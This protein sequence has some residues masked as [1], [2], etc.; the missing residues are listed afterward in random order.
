[1][2]KK[3]NSSI[4]EISSY[5]FI[6][7]FLFILVGFSVDLFFFDIKLF[8]ANTSL[9]IG[10]GLLL[11]STFLIFWAQHTGLRY[12]KHSHKYDELEHHHLKKGAFRFTRNPNYLGMGLLVLGLG[13]LMNSLAV[14]V[15]A[16]LSFFVV[17]AWFIPREEALLRERH[18]SH[19]EK[20]KDTTG[21]W[22]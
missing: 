16:V 11:V 20:Y 8:S 13:V 7:Y 21:R 6:F 22:F 3:E 19:F 18:G 17:N 5:S 9:Y 1:M 2:F 10:V 15:L 4:S 14:I 12:R